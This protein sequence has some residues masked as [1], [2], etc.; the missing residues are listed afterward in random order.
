MFSLAELNDLTVSRMVGQAFWNS[1]APS[2]QVAL[3]DLNWMV[4]RV[5]PRAVLAR[6]RTAREVVRNCILKV[7]RNGPVLFLILF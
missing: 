7:S 1:A 2:V 3:A 4:W 6:D 5:Q